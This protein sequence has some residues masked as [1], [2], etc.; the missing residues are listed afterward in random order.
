MD[1]LSEVP[2]SSQ[3]TGHSQMETL[4]HLLPPC[5]LFSAKAVAAYSG[6]VRGSSSRSPVVWALAQTPTSGDGVES[7]EAMASVTRKTP[8]AARTWPGVPEC[9]ARTQAKPSCV[10]AAA[11]RTVGSRSPWL[12]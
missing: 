6:G 12:L 7:G 4:E 8:K 11:D 1:Q 9:A 2:P 5:L 10:G 3:S